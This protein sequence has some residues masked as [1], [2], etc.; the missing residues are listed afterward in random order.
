M[1]FVPNNIFDMIIAV[2]T[3]PVDSEQS[4]W[5]FGQYPIYHIVSSLFGQYPI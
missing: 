1:V 2:L 3:L 5:T 4:I